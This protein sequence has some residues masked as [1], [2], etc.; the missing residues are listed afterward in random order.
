MANKMLIDAS[1]PEETR[2]VVVRGNRVEEFDFESASKKPLRGNIYLAKVMRVEPSLQAAFVDYGGNRHGFLAFSEIHPDYYQIPVADRQALLE[3]EARA[4]REDQEDQGRAIRR[5]RRSR[6]GPDG[7]RAE[8]RRAQGEEII[9]GEVEAET[10]G[11][12]EDRIAPEAAGPVPRGEVAAEEGLL[13]SGPEREEAP[14]GASRAEAAPPSEESGPG[15]QAGDMQ[16]AETRAEDLE[17]QPLE[18]GPDRDDEDGGAPEIDQLGGDALEEM[19]ARPPRPRRSY[20]IQEV[21][22]RRQ[23][24]LVQ[25]VKEE[26]GNKGAA[27]TTY[28]S[29]AGRYSV[30]MPNTA[31]GGGISRKI[32]D[33]ADRQRL[34]AIAQELDV[35]EGMGVI[36]RTAGASRTKAEIKR[37]FEYL[38]RM[39]ETVR[40]TTLRSS[41]PKLVYEEGSLIKRAIR[42]LY[43][44]DID[45]IVVAGEEAYREAKEFMRL[46]APS[47]AKMVQ[48]YREPQ[49]M[50]AKY[51]VESQLDAMFS[52]HVTLKSGGYIVINQ[53]EALVAI[54]VNSGRSTREH[55]IEDTALRTNLEAAEEIARQLRLRDLAGL[56]V[57]D[58][59]DMEESRNNRLVERRLKEALK[60]D[61]ARLQIGRMSAFGL[62]EMSRQR[63]RTGVLEGS[64]II[65]PHCAGA[66]TV[67]STA[68][69]AL[70]VLRGLEDAL[71]KD[72]AYDIGVKAR[73]PVA[74][75]ILNQK[76]SHLQDLEKR[77]GV[78]VTVT[79]DD[80]LTNTNYYTL[81]RGEPAAGLRDGPSRLPEEAPSLVPA[82]DAALSPAVEPS[83]LAEEAKAGLAVEEREVRDQP[84][85]DTEAYARQ[86]RR[87]R[88]KRARGADRELPAV[89]PSAPQPP[90]DA[91]RAVAE[92]GGLNPAAFS[93]A[94]A[95]SRESDSPLTQGASGLDAASGRKSAADLPG[96]RQSRQIGASP[97]DEPILIEFGPDPGHSDVEGGASAASE[98]SERTLITPAPAEPGEGKAPR[99]RHGQGARRVRGAKPRRKELPQAT[100]PADQMPGE[101]VQV[102]TE[103][104]QEHGHESVGKSGMAIV[105]EPEPAPFA[106]SAASSVQEEGP[107]AAPEQPQ[108]PE[109][110]ISERPKR[111]GWWQRAR[112]GGRG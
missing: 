37:D 1:H 41:A 97:A 76:R 62:L 67:R 64:T 73:S 35:P 2:V 18:E 86:R 17:L 99:R 16:S 12:L 95:Q 27:L 22:K 108:E 43:H 28:L 100:E 51:G 49:P 82:D 3:E 38:L 31:R 8:K 90:D 46:L 42:D 20:K 91:L 45:E 32:T 77:F 26:R 85:G 50:F 10:P 25:V 9:F 101:A 29:L 103:F 65:C 92:I 53:T 11:G 80:S 19:P 69:I 30:L 88:R 109:S 21:I 44:K 87:R 40:E 57:I 78:S 34:K 4:Q 63:M 15:R 84:D 14:D 106:G 66:G 48:P 54:D 111:T 79:A 110:D 102:A 7:Q 89:S 58:F 39:W 5:S 81:Y 59:I 107:F 47:H 104:A 68:S 71:I 33:S 61:R 93:M 56:I 60:N 105:P 96:T 36:V 24:L 70:H 23:V 6:R 74:L 55:N 72:S 94:G 112:P 13:P 98:E 52:N 83:E 75:Y